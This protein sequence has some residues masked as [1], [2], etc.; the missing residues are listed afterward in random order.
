MRGSGSTLKCHGS[1]TLVLRIR[2]YFFW[3]QI[4]GS[5]ILNYRSG[6]PINTDS[7]GSYKDI[8]VVSEKKSLVN[9]AVNNNYSKILNFFYKFSFNLW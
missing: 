8:F 9:Y 4:L 3:F 6:R 7:A 2:I 5:V 1:A